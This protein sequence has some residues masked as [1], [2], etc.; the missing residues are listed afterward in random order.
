VALLFRNH[1]I[2]VADIDGRSDLARQL[3]VHRADPALETMLWERVDALLDER[4][5]LGDADAIA[6]AH[7]P[8]GS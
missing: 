1:P 6:G 8:V 4:L 7:Q 2:D 3:R 5:R